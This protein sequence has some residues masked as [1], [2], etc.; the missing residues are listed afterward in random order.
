MKS[1][2][3]ILFLSIQLIFVNLSYS[4]QT[5]EKSLEETTALFQKQDPLSLRLNFS[6]KDVKRNTNDST[7]IQSTLAYKNE[8]S[9]WKSL[10]IKLRARGNYRRENCY[11]VPLKLKIKKSISKGTLFEGNKKL[12]VVLPCLIAKNNDDYVLKEYLAYRLYALISPYHYKTRLVNIEFIEDKGQ[13]TK[14]HQLMGFLIEDL[15]KIAERHDGRDLGRI[16]HPLQ[17]D[18]ITSLQNDY[19]QY[20]IANTD[21]S[22][23]QQHNEKLLFINNKYICIPFDFDMSGLVNAEYAMVSNI[24]NLSGNITGVTDRIYK[25]YKRDEVLMQKVR[26]DFLNHKTEMLKAVDDLREYFQDTTQFEKAKEF[27]IDFFEI[28]ESD[29][30]FQKNIVG[31]VRTR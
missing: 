21:F 17:Q 7:Y 18:A 29:K 16:V 5:A 11:Y 6:I 19:F 3:L 25:G 1:R 10:K 4:Q 9:L 2:M 12:K 15:D 31:R 27:V 8:D 14:E 22:T 26:Q 23:K 13:R 28:L 24:Q 20:L 30:K